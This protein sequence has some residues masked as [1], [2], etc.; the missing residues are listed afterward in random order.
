V[1]TG[2]DRL[3]LGE[4]SG[5]ARDGADDQAAARC[6][7]LALAME[8]TTKQLLGPVLWLWQRQQRGLLAAG[9]WQ[10]QL[11]LPPTTAVEWL[12]LP[13]SKHCGVSMSIN[14]KL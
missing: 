8:P 12:W 6:M 11:Q 7:V 5:A 13:E 14:Y 10:L 1:F 3:V 2:Q 4:L 9:Y